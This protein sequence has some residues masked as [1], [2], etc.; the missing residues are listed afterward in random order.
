MSQPWITALA[1][2]VAPLLMFVLL[3]IAR[4]VVL[5]VIAALPRG[6]RLRRWLVADIRRNQSASARE[7]GT[8]RSL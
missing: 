6:S 7:D 1:V 2:L 3:V 5:A 8:S 4:A